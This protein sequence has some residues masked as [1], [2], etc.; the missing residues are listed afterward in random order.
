[1]IICYG[2]AQRPGGGSGRPQQET[3]VTAASGTPSANPPARISLKT[4]ST[5]TVKNEITIKGEKV[6]YT[7]IAGTSP[8]LDADNQP[9][10]NVFILI[11]KGMISK[12][13]KPDHWLFRLMAVRVLLPYGWK[14][15]IPVPAY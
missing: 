2:A 13:K 11:M 7:A 9:I 1:M 14:S 3:T 6:S 5:V 15:V 8:V 4:D 10:A 12:I